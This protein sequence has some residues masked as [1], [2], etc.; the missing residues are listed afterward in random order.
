MWT[1]VWSNC[2]FETEGQS[3]S[4]L[5]FHCIVPGPKSGKFSGFFVLG[6]DMRKKM[7]YVLSNRYYI[8]NNIYI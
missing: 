8:T 7:C 5:R 4:F 2:V 3:F 6:I 1:A